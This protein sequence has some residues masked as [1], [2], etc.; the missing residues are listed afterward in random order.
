MSKERNFRRRIRERIVKTGESY[1]IARM[2]LSNEG[3]S[4]ETPDTPP[5]KQAAAPRFKLHLAL[6]Q[7]GR[8]VS[9]P[10]ETPEERAQRIARLWNRVDSELKRVHSSR[11]AARL[12]VAL[13]KKGPEEEELENIIAN[14][15]T[16]PTAFGRQ[17]EEAA[18]Y[19]AAVAAEVRQ[20]QAAFASIPAGVARAIASI[21]REVAQALAAHREFLRF[22]PPTMAAAQEA[23]D[24]VG[25]PLS[26]YVDNVG[27]AAVRRLFVETDSVMAALRDAFRPEL[28]DVRAFIK[29]ETAAIRSL[30]DAPAL[31]ASL[32]WYHHIQA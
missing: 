25:P 31:A 20:Y 10:P 2:H 23:I 16:L 28:D 9:R 26:G 8:A 15:R 29:R 22:L 32:S 27:G 30:A 19:I 7:V 21:P 4:A 1:S 13:N 24:S 18:R 6:S 3:P 14:L 5:P 11:T 17:L 12:L